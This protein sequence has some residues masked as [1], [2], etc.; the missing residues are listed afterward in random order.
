MPGG[1]CFLNDSSM[2]ACVNAAVFF[3]SEDIMEC[4]ENATRKQYLVRHCDAPT[5]TC[6]RKMK[7]SSRTAEG[8]TAFPTSDV[9]DQASFCASIDWVASFW[10]REEEL[11]GVG[12]YTS[13]R[14]SVANSRAKNRDRTSLPR[15]RLSY[16]ALI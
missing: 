8:L 4:T 13:E 11:S 3:F 15:R 10:S 16:P 5:D 2:R 6:L 14:F 1:T 9:H 7:S 12:E